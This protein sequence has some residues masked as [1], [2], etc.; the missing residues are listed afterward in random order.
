[1]SAAC[2]TG[3]DVN[4]SDPLEPMNRVVFAVNDKVDHYVAEPIAKG[5]QV[6]TPSPVRSAVSNF[7]GNLSDVGNIANN[8]LQGKCVE[9]AESLM[10]VAINSVLGIGGLIDIAT[11]A[12]L[13]R[14]PQDFGLTLGVW[15]VPSGT[16]VVLPFFGP[17]TVRDGVGIYVN[18]WFAPVTY[19]DPAWRNPLFGAGVVDARTNML[20]ATELLSQAALDKYSFVRDAY[21]Q[22]RRYLLHSGAGMLPAYEDYD[23]SETPE[24]RLDNDGSVGVARARNE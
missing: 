17:S 19:V 5:Y 14:H 24:A 22:R 20:G 16:Y 6:V 7:Y 15:G 4:P 9:A 1:M 13:Q 2:A 8:L 18:H 12:G 11:P 21:L 23:A 3:P 10:R